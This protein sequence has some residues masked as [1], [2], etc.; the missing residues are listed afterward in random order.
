MPRRKAERLIEIAALVETIDFNVPEFK[1]QLRTELKQEE[2]DFNKM[3]HWIN[4]EGV[5]QYVEIWKIHRSKLR[6]EGVESKSLMQQYHH[7][8]QNKHNEKMFIYIMKYLRN[9]YNM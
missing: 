4:A 5:D 9:R 3:R 8:Y 6:E 2:P 1:R 7:H